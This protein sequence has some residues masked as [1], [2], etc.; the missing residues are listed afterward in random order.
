M[1]LAI[2]WNRLKSNLDAINAINRQADE[3]CSRLALTDADAAGR[4]LVCE[5]M[6]EAGLQVSIDRIGNIFG[7]QSGEGAPVMTGS[8]IDTV[9]TGGRFDGTYGVLAGI[10]A[11]RTLTET[12]CRLKRPLCVAVFTNEEGVRFQPDMM[13]SLVFAGGLDLEVALNAKD[14][15]GVRLGD[16]LARHGYAGD[17]P[18]GA[19]IPHAFI[20]LHIEQGPVLE[21][22][23]ELLGAVEDLQGI[24][25]QEIVFNGS[26][27]HSGTT[28]MKGRR[29][30][31]YCAGRTIAFVRELVEKMGGGQVGTVGAVQLSPNLVNVIAR[32]ARLTVDLRNVDEAQLIEAER[33]LEG[34]LAQLSKDQNVAVSTNRLVRTQPVTFDSRIIEI[35]EEASRELGHSARRMTS[36]AGHDAQ[37]MASL[38][39]TGMIFVPSIG[40]ISHNPREDTRSEDLELGANVLLRAMHNLAAQ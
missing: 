2:N 11:I 35:V 38:C 17:V 6:R 15:D 19:I 25:W 39:P 36:G 40:G 3:S 22:E 27:N 34:F 9:A 1:T 37:M 32:E 18:V 29:D 28:P 7:T 14:R 31:A 21:S 12:R 23:G 16:E 4:G 5:W 24:S 8:H 26:S 13:G 33:Q 20:E 10:E 30:A